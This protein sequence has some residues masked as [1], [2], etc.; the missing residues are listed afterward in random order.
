ML[1]VVA[2]IAATGAAG[3]GLKRASGPEATRRVA[4]AV[5]GL[6]LWVLVPFIAF[7]TLARLELTAGVGLGVLL[8]YAE[9]L[10]TGV[11]AFLV[12]SRLLRLDRPATGA[13]VVVAILANTGYLGV[14]LTAVLLG[15]EA[16]APAIAYDTA[17]S[18]PMFLV[19][20][21]A[22]GA[23]LGTVAAEPDASRIRTFLARNPPLLALAAG[24]LAPD[25]LAPDALVNVAVALATYAVLPLGFFALGLTLATEPVAAR[26]DAP[27]AAAIV[28]RLVVA[29]AVFLALAAAVPGVPDAYR[30]QAAMPSAIASLIVAHATGLDLRLT[31]AAVAWTTGVFLVGAALVSVL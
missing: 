12:G 21:F 3:F 23:V 27:L 9:R 31:A 13:L 10:I 25:A 22:V 24:L 5:L 26:L 1:L 8:G 18:T 16:V 2:T 17:V 14:P 20:G 4:R 7:F 30:L 28:L 6:L 15:R 11:V 29:P 19:A